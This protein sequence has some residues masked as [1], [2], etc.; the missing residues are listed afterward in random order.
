MGL[1]IDWDVWRAG[2]DQMTFAD[3]QE[4]YRQVADLFPHQESANIGVAGHAFDKIDDVK[5]H[6]LSV[7]ELGGWN[8]RLAS[9]ML[10]RGDIKT[11]VNYDIVEV[12]QACALPGYW[13][14]VLDDW[15]WKGPRFIGDVFVA[16]H[17]I[18][19]LSTEHLADLIVW[20]DTP[21]VYFEAPLDDGPIDWRG[22]PGSHKL[23][24]GWDS[25]RRLMKA[26]GYAEVPLDTTSAYLWSK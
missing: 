4:F 9:H 2:Y 20:L 10:A 25:V 11:W 5:R 16:C 3:Q 21:W 15:L 22:Y 24:I 19:H 13:L 12:P 18:E 6:D 14:C 1:D 8:G 17:T 7:V 23:E 26:T